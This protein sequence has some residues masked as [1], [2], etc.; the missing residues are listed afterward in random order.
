MNH[1]AK[2]APSHTIFLYFKVHQIQ[3]SAFYSNMWLLKKYINKETQIANP[4]GRIFCGVLKYYF[5]V[6]VP[7]FINKFLLLEIYFHSIKFQS[8]ISNFSL[9]YILH[10][11][12][13]DYALLLIVEKM[14]CLKCLKEIPKNN[15]ALLN[16]IFRSVALSYPSNSLL[17][18]P[19]TWQY[20]WSSQWEYIWPATQ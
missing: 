11:L 14:H 2:H 5:S 7:Y 1:N 4:H 10:H 12:F 19:T 9:N 18:H 13:G 15:D 6:S 20:V 16:W 8:N 17:Q 3:R